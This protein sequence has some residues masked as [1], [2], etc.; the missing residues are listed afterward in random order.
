MLRSDLDVRLAELCSK[1]ELLLEDVAALHADMQ[2]LRRET[3]ERQE[4]SSFLL[5]AVVDD[6]AIHCA[7]VGA[8]PVYRMKQQGRP[9]GR[10][11]PVCPAPPPP[12]KAAR[13]T[14]TC[15]PGKA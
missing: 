5:K 14:A 10:P 8:H 2:G 3:Q 13:T 1:F 9:A 4:L 11:C 12:A 6:L 15:G 7:D